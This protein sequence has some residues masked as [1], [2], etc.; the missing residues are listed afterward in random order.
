MDRIQPVL[1]GLAT[2]SAFFLVLGLGFD[3]A[4]AQQ[5]PAG[6]VAATS[7]GRALTGRWEGSLTALGQNLEIGVTFEG[8]VTPLVARIDI[9]AQGAHGLQLQNVSFDPPRVHFELP[10]GPG[11]A[12]WDGLLRGD[13]IEGEFTQAGV[14]GTFTL[15][16][17]PDTDTQE[18]DTPT[19]VVR[20]GR[21]EDATPR[22]RHEEVT[23]ENGEIKLAGTLSFPEG[24]GPHPAVVLI[25]GSGAQNRDEEI[26]GFQPFR[27]IAEHLNREGIAVLRYDDR[28]VAGS[29]GSVADA[30]SADFAGD[31]LSAVDLLKKH[32]SIDAAAVGLLGHSE[33]GL[34][35]P[36]AVIRSE[37]IAFLVL[38]AGPGV[39]GAEILLR[40]GELIGRANGA[41]R[42]A[43]ERQQTHQRLI[44]SMLRRDASRDELEAEL[45][46]M[47]REGVEAMPPERRQSIHDV[48]A[49]VATQLAPQLAATTSTWFRY[50]L[51]HDPREALR[52]TRVP[53]LALF[54]ELDLQVPPAQNRGPMAEALSAA[55]NADVTIEVIPGANHLFQA[56]VT[57]SPGEYATLEKEFV[58]GLLDR[59][60]NWIL[61]R[62][63]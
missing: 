38:L 47:I 20:P 7:D 43:I 31:V 36:L 45:A 58:P 63:R 14:A 30:T 48:D 56:A 44:F 10:A 34:V 29:T 40:Q 53:V 18:A 37:D 15:S 13:T 9:P 27:L 54:G 22:Y 50:F 25:S 5:R 33:G 19:G 16:R 8:A 6:G 3:S 39:P 2:L 4:T 12:V 62:T 35:A 26:F 11:L 60:A 1:S 24:R 42:A 52:Q 21:P 55:G 23:F 51:D 46:R 32:T 41:S 61:T 49:F 59:I 28:G 17:V 57:G